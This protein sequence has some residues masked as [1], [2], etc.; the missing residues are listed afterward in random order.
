MGHYICGERTESFLLWILADDSAAD[1]TQNSEDGVPKQ[2]VN[3]KV[4]NHCQPHCPYCTTASVNALRI[5]KAG[6]PSTRN[7]ECVRNMI[8]R[9]AVRQALSQNKQDP[10]C[11][12]KANCSGHRPNEVS[13]G[14]VF[15][16]PPHLSLRLPFPPREAPNLVLS[17][18]WS[19]HNFFEECRKWFSPSKS[20]AIKSTPT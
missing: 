16:Y 8:P 19:T 11:Y 20:C 5:D 13:L 18:R 6:D 12:G 4:G 2:D 15:N 9:A 7:C 1:E 14:H 3:D 10:R 17:S